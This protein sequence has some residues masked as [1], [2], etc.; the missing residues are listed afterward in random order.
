[1]SDR[2]ILL[3]T[4]FALTRFDNFTRIVGICNRGTNSVAVILI[5]SGLGYPSS[6]PEW[7]CL[8]FI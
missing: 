6:N 8:L 4:I 2:W 5:R 7:G 1:M 3:V